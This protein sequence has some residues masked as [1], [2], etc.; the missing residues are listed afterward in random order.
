MKVSRF[1]TSPSCWNGRRA[2]R[3]TR[4]NEEANVEGFD[5]KVAVVTGG[6][7]GLGRVIALALADRGTRI[8]GNDIFRDESGGS[9]AEGVVG[10]IESAGGEAF[11]DHE[12]ASSWS[13]AERLM[14][15]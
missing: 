13:G 4:D 10:E 7:R 3:P 9:A 11:A 5:S 12:D 1:S 15:A 14:Q 8:A 6:G 2:G